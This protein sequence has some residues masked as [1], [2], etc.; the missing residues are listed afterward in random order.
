MVYFFLIAQYCTLFKPADPA[1][2]YVGPPVEN[3]SSAA[4]DRQSG[5]NGG[6]PSVDMDVE[7]PSVE[8]EVEEVTPMVSDHFLL[9]CISTLYNIVTDI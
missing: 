2:K 8:P 4:P 7:T 3:T 9:W 5:M 6:R 1:V